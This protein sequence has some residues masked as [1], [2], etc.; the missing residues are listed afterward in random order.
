LGFFFIQCQSDKKTKIIPVARKV[1]SKIKIN[2]SISNEIQK[3][4]EYDFF[5][6]KISDFRPSKNVYSYE[7]NTPL[8]TDYAFKGRFLYIPSGKKMVYKEKEVLD[9]ESGSIIIKNFYYPKDFKK[10][11]GDKNIIETRLLIKEEED[12][13]K[14]LTYVWNDKQDDAHLNIIGGEKQVSWK[15]F[16]G[17]TQNINYLIPNQTQCK[18]CHMSGKKISP[19]GP[20][21]G[22]LNRDNIYHGMVQNQLEYFESQGL[23]KELP[24]KEKW[25][26]IPVWNMLDSGSLED[27]AKAYLHIN[28]AHC[29]SDV[30]PA[31]NSGLNLTYWETDRRSR[32]IFKPPIAAGKG[33]GSLKYSIVPGQ[34][35]NSILTYRLK[36][37]E[38][39]VMM[40]EIGRT[41]FHKEGL[42]LIEDYIKSL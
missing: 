13:W 14:V 10:P 22:Q 37:T 33:S 26:F 16:N 28:C 42:T 5:E 3:L 11:E 40:P 18:S 31:K 39:E 35:E 25:P 38:P 23:L 27:R 30:G 41:G 17:K 20:I 4:S 15:D 36:S 9:F 21:A 2:S 12:L 6:G 8:F 7:L 1:V 24:K 32:G 29:H 34:P 19:I